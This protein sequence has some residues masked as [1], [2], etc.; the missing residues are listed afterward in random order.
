MFTNSLIIGLLG[1][2][3]GCS[4]PYLKEPDHYT[5]PLP[6]VALAPVRV[7]CKSPT[8]W[9]L[10][11]EL[12]FFLEKRLQTSEQ[13]KI[14]GGVFL[15][16]HQRVPEYSMWHSSDLSAA[17]MLLPHDFIALVEIT[18]YMEVRNPKE[19]TY[20]R[21][22]M[23]IIH[24]KPA[25]YHV[26]AYIRIIDLTGPAI[27]VALQETIEWKIPV[28]DAQLASQKL[29][30]HWRER[31]YYGTGFAVV[32]A[33]FTRQLASRIEERV[34]TAWQRRLPLSR[35]PKSVRQKF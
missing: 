11:E 6:K 3:A 14:S 8:P 32:S 24:V 23:P 13:L 10:S 5:H 34:T 30:S 18:H 2:L 31:N 27:R 7:R 12:S 25:Y 29:I 22:M 17:K 35:Y 4:M 28:S 16:A 20:D 15:R 9:D 19:S 21:V 33:K 1:L 26:Q